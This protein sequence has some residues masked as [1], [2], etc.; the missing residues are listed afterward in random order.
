V[1]LLGVVNIRT[2]GW[3][4]V[5]R[6][7]AHVVRVMLRCRLI[8]AIGER[9]AVLE[10]HFGILHAHVLVRQGA[11][12]VLLAGSIEGKLRLVLRRALWAVKGRSIAESLVAWKGPVCYNPAKRIIPLM[13][14][15]TCAS[16][17]EELDEIKEKSIHPIRDTAKVVIIRERE[18]GGRD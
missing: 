18:G 3:L 8:S 17:R 1:L 12:I 4:I 2:L 5:A 7:G 16:V 10:N 14:L 13:S 11:P 6:R 15:S 9:V